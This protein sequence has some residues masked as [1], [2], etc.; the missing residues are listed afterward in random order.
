MT[1]PT[2]SEAE[3]ERLRA[4]L[5][6]TKSEL[7]RPRGDGLSVG[8]H[9]ALVQRAQGIAKT[10]HAELVRAQRELV[11]ARAE[12]KQ[13][14]RRPG[15]AHRRSPGGEA[16][17][18]GGGPGDESRPPNQGPIPQ[19]ERQA[20]ELSQAAPSWHVHGRLWTSDARWQGDVPDLPAELHRGESKAGGCPCRRRPLP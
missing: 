6:R 13:L 16:S 9:I 3:L 1:R 11:I 19:G 8:E 12:L 20:Q 2:E 14:Q 7:H 10:D 15:A 5:E 18:A 4:E 17:G